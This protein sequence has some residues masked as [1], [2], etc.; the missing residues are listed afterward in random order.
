M[1]ATSRF[2]SFVGKTVQSGSKPS[3]SIFP[4]LTLMSTKD[5]FQLNK[6]ARALLGVDEGSYVVLIDINLGE[7]M[8][9]D[10]NKRWHITKGYVDEKG[11]DKGAKLGKNGAFSY[12]GIYAA[13]NINEP[14]ITEGTDL[15]LVEKAKG[16][17]YETKGDK[18]AF[19]AVNKITY[20]LE[21]V[22]VPGEDEGT[23]IDTFEVAKGV[24]QPV[25]VLT[26]RIETPHVSVA[27]IEE[28][29]NED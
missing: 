6:K 14:E 15:D 19:V 23:V 27:G 22:T 11:N 2:S 24:V 29:P 17:I 1:E 7:V 26:K 8:T 18:E 16:R 25:F 12:A 20:T 21:R 4:Q 5:K 3:G 10:T 13:I 9:T 28:V